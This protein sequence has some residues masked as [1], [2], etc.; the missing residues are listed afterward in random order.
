MVAHSP[1][2]VVFG[3]SKE[4]LSKRYRV[5]PALSVRTLPYSSLFHTVSWPAEAAVVDWAWSDVP[6]PAAPA[7]AV[8][9]PV[10]AI[11]PAPSVGV[12]AAPTF[13][14]DVDPCS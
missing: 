1:S 12:E 11:V 3:G 2:Q 14:E 13:C 4:S 8:P 7:P 6:E 10:P 9:A 5:R